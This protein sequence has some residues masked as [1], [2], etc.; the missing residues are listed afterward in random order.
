AEYLV[1]AC[2][3]GFAE[4]MLPHSNAGIL[5]ADEMQALKRSNASLGL[6]LES[7]SPRLREKGQAHYYCPDKDPAVRMRMHEEAGLLRI[8]FT[9]GI[10]LGIGGTGG[11]RVDPLLPL[12]ELSGR[13]G[14]VQE[15]IVQPFHAKDDTPMRGLPSLS[16]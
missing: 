14:P 6:M 4:G 12:R 10:L 11:G 13:Y 5:S 1:E 8:P 16:N 7:T 9:R 15:T 3:L 2:E